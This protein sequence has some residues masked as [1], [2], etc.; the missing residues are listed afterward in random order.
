MHFRLKNQL[1]EVVSLPFTSITKRRDTKKDAAQ[2]FYSLLV[3]QKVILALL[4]V[5]V[6]DVYI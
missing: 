4:F 2:K 3:L 5:Y 6:F 1:A